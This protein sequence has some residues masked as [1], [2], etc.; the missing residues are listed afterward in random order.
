[1]LLAYRFWHLDLAPFILDEPTFLRA[2]A[3]EVASGHWLSASPIRGTQGVTYGPTVFWFYALVQTIFGAEPHA[4]LLAMCAMVTVAH[5]ALA[6]ALW[7]YFDRPR[8]VI[9]AL[10]A[11][12][13]ASPFQFFWARLAWDQTVDIAA[14]WT[15]VLLTRRSPFTVA[16]AALLGLV[17]GLGV[18]SHL[19][20]APLFALTLVYL[21]LRERRALPVALTAATALVVNLPYLHFLL[22]EPRV[23][24]PHHALDLRWLG[25]Q[26]V[27]PLRVSSTFKVDYFFDAQWTEFL[28]GHETSMAI[29]TAFSM[30]TLGVLTLVGLVL[31]LKARRDLAALALALWLGTAIFHLAFGLDRQPHYMFASYWIV[32]LGLAAALT[33]LPKKRPGR[34]WFGP[35]ARLPHASALHRA[36]DVVRAHARRHRRYA[37]RRH[38]RCADAT[39]A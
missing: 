14:A 8:W 7:D 18:S 11:W 15:V 17:L 24:G 29:A 33:S 25:D 27:Q 19:M 32:G 26:L 37:L 34:R 5:L 31:A 28:L 3:A 12:I 2:A 38:A 13:A 35:R 6:W 10:I 36:L 20:I 21:A 1:M 22:S 9:E 4:S 23:P 16:R 30:V 39:R